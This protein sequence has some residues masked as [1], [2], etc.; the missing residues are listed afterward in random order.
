M[1]YP[2]CQDLAGRVFKTWNFVEVIMVQT[3]VNGFEMALDVTKIHYPAG[4][5]VNRSLHMNP[6]VEGMPV[7]TC[8][9]VS[10]WYIG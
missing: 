7:Q 1:P 6:H 4:L 5:L 8:T 3:P 9:L 2:H 10:R